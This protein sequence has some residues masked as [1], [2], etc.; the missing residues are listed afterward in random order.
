MVIA[1]GAGLLSSM[2][3]YQRD[4]AGVIAALAQERAAGG[5][6]TRGAMGRVADLLWAAF[7]SQGVS[8]VGFYLPEGAVPERRPP[9]GGT[10]ASPSTH[11]IL[12]ERR[13]KPACSP[14]G[15]HGVCG[16]GYLHRRSVVVGDVR[17]M[18]PDYIAC[19][20]RDQSE[21]VVPLLTAAGD[22]VGVLDVDSYDLSAFSEG[23]ARGLEAVLMAAGL[24][25]GG[26]HVDV[27]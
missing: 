13:D 7:S 24:T 15:L 14:I 23:D 3:T 21:V 22:C 1:A 10:P 8:W 18:G 26:A 16:R 20:P 5:F 4:Y 17:V 12:G 6:G 9:A 27:L 2:R 19:D 11:L 25:V